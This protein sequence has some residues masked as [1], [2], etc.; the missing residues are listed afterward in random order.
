MARKKSSPQ[1]V[2]ATEPARPEEQF[3]YEETSAPPPRQR[4][5]TSARRGGERKSIGARSARDR[6]A[7]RSTTSAR[8]SSGELSQEVI[9]QMLEHPTIEISED[10]LRKEYSFVLSDLR[11]MGL[12]SIALIVALIAL[13]EILPK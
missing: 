6:R 11:S 10:E 1:P 3:R 2:T 9:S 8:R 4:P 5:S 13:A 7:T 12:L